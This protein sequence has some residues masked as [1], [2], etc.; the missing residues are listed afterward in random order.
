MTESTALSAT[1]IQKHLGLE[2]FDSLRAE[3]EPW[4]EHCYVPTAHFHLMVRWRSALAFGKPGSGKTALRLIMEHRIRQHNIEQPDRLVWIVRHDDLNPILAAWLADEAVPIL[5]GD[6][7]YRE[8]PQERG[9][10]A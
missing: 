2:A 8:A 10:Q 9:S 6:E 1:D 7:Q 4:L 3:Y 5:P